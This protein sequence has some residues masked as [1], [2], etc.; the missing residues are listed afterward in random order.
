MKNTVLL[1]D[2]DRNLLMGLK[3]TLR[4]KPYDIVMATSAREGLQILAG[5]PIDVVVSDEKMPEMSGTDFLTKVRVLYPDTTRIML[6]GEATL[7]AA[8]R[9][10]NEGEI[11]RFLRKPC[12]LADLAVAIAQAL[13]HKQQ[14]VEHRRLLRQARSQGD[15]AQEIEEENPG[16]AAIERDATGAIVI[17]EMSSDFESFVEEFNA[18][19]D[20]PDTGGTA[21]PLPGDR[22]RA[23]RRSAGR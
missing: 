21:R 3:R 15:K 14:M 9:A 1:V 17:E 7:D 5:M 11:F 23:E 16:I 6:T 19:A 4:K 22:A 20:R 12:S 18:R 2:D 8:M 13:E 10:I